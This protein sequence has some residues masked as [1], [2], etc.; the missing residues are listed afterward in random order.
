[1]TL[2]WIG[3]ISKKMNKYSVC[4]H[5]E[6]YKLGKFNLSDNIIKRGLN[7]NFDKVA[8]ISNYDEKITGLR[9]E[10]SKVIYDR[11][12][13]A[14]YLTLDKCT[15]QKKYKLSNDKKYILYV[16]GPSKLKGAYTLIDAI[17]YMKPYTNLEFIFLGW[18]NESRTKEEKLLRQKIKEKDIESKIIFFDLTDK[19]EIFFCLSD[20]VVFPSTKAHQSRP[21]YEAGISKK[22]I[23]ISE[24]EN[25]KE[26]ISNNQTGFTF[27][28]KDP[29]ELADIIEKVV[30]MPKN[31]LDIIID[32]N[33]KNA[34]KRHDFKTLQKDLNDL[35][36]IEGEYNRKI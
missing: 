20:I 12:E 31:D 24:F 9:N 3:K 4:F 33:F 22:P 2:F 34:L 16:G 14:K 18:S 13:V 17:E 19:P 26:F 32:K 21:V 27:N 11:V 10:K 23:I 30:S 8:F 6:S 7:K 36:K 15:L 5:R 35:L 1:M 25:T 28:N 29:K